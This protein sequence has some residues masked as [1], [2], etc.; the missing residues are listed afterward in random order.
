MTVKSF[1][2]L[3]FEHDEYTFFAVCQVDGQQQRCMV[4]QNGDNYLIKGDSTD[5]S[6][7]RWKYTLKNDV[8]ENYSLFVSESMKENKGLVQASLKAN[9][10]PTDDT[11]QL[12]KKIANVTAKQKAD[13]AM[14]DLLNEVKNIADSYTQDPAKLLELAVFRSQFYNYS[15]R[16]IL[17][18]EKQIKGA[19][20]V[21]SFKAF[22]NLGEKLAKAHNQVDER[23]K[24]KYFGVKRGAHGAKIL[25]PAEITYICI[26]ER[27]NEWKQFKEATKKQQED[28]NAGLLMGRKKLVFKVG[29]VFDIAQTNIPT[30]YYPELCSQG[31]SS[32]KHS[33][34]ADGLQQYI[35]TECNC[36]VIYTTEYGSALRGSYNQS[37]IITIN[38]N[39][40]DTQ[41]LSTMAHELGHYFM[42]G[43][44]GNRRFNVTVSQ[45]EMEADIYSIMLQ[46]KFGIAPNDN[47]K[48]HF[49]QHYKQYD[50]T[51]QDDI[52]SIEKLEKIFDYVSSK[53]SKTYPKIKEYVDKTLLQN[54]EEVISKDTAEA[55]T[56]LREIQA[57]SDES[58]PFYT[59]I[60]EPDVGERL[61]DELKKAE[62]KFAST[63]SENGVRLAVSSKDKKLLLNTAENIGLKFNEDH[64]FAMKTTNVDDSSAVAANAPAIGT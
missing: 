10:L 57:N 29:T 33:Q 7:K 45:M 28:Y 47:I 55:A 21:G 6:F 54:A 37:D 5:G 9:G 26:N 12:L 27:R 62:I 58:I 30:E 11:N 64:S 61:L 50:R 20:F 15:L 63:Y 17:L 51:L 19:M 31:Y 3:D 40:Q 4:W 18:I 60:L 43:H 39:L 46:N 8:A 48:K 16:N 32:E 25:V 35:E 41:K 42:H 44:D 22:E 13:K 52:P 38:A 56:S 2:L 14:E 24:L 34:I 49:K 53:F 1:K 36:P 59:S 23:G